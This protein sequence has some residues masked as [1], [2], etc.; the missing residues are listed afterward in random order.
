MSYYNSFIVT[1]Q[2]RGEQLIPMGLIHVLTINFAYRLDPNIWK[3]C[4]KKTLC[5]AIDL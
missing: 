3:A 1:I 4:K 2:D 5:D